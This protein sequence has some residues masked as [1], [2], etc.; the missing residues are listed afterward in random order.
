MIK[1]EEQMVALLSDKT[2]G[3]IWKIKLDDATETIV[4]ENR[5]LDKKVLFYAYDFLNQVFL[6]KHFSFEEDWLLGLDFVFNGIAYF[7]GFES[8]Y[9]PVHKGIIAY[10]LKQNQIL[11]QNFSISVQQYSSEGVVVFDPKVFPRVFQLV[12]LKTG[13]FISKLSLETIYQT[14]SI[15]NQIIIPELKEDNKLWNSSHELQYKDLKIVALYK[16]EE[17]ITNQYLQIYKNGTLLFEDLLNQDIQKIGI[18][19]F[20]LWLD[21]LIYIRNKSEILS[22]LV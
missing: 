14:P 7:H 17:N 1:K 2:E 10:D 8:E 9:S 4:W 13:N 11:W 19:T 22:Y 21:K 12:D 18:D 16:I 6:I 3:I 5:T 20:F 15:K